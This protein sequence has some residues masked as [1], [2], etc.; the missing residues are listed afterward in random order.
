MYRSRLSHL[1]SFNLVLLFVAIFSLALNFNPSTFTRACSPND[2]PVPTPFSHSPPVY[3]DSPSLGDDG[4]QARLMLSPSPWTQR[5]AR[6]DVCTNALPGTIS[7]QCTPSNTTET[8]LCCMHSL[9]DHN[10]HKLILSG[11]RP[12][13]QFPTCDVLLGVGFCCVSR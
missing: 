11:V 2:W 10:V 13:S 8:T 3:S 6:R 12:D 5:L 9:L 7:S 4:Y 1:W